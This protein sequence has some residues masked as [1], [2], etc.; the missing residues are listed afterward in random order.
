MTRTSTSQVARVLAPCFIAA[1]VVMLNTAP[2]AAAD[3]IVPQ[4]GS[5]SADIIINAL[6]SS[7]FDTQINWLQGRPNVPLSECRVDAIHNPNG[8]MA[9]MIMLSTVYVDVSC[10]NAK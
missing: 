5:A 8:P 1:A 2:S 7:G 3:P 9:S 10:P 6:T 4:A